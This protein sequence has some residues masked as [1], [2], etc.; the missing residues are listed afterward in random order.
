[1]RKSLL[2]TEGPLKGLLN[3]SYWEDNEQSHLDT[4]VQESPTHGSRVTCGDRWLWRYLWGGSRDRKPSAPRCWRGRRSERRWSREAG[5][6]GSS[7]TGLEWRKQNW[8]RKIQAQNWNSFTCVG[9]L[10]LRRWVTS[11]VIIKLTLLLTKIF[12]WAEMLITI[13][14]IIS[15]W[16]VLQ[17]KCFAS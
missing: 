13:A 11:T 8:K 3:V 4:Q 6:P 5:S 1:M 17:S 9:L 12:L 16:H 15:L 10:P 7:N 14:G 2:R